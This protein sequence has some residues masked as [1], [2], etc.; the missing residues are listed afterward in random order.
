MHELH[1]A[2]RKDEKCH[3]FKTLLA[4]LLFL[5]CGK[6]QH[7]GGQRQNSAWIRARS[8]PSSYTYPLHHSSRKSLSYSQACKILCP[9][10][11]TQ[12]IRCPV[13]LNSSLC[14]AAK[15]KCL[16]SHPSPGSCASSTCTHL[17]FF[18]FFIFLFSLPNCN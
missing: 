3:S 7:W 9:N 16:C 2:R 1:Q 17:L 5:L 4:A 15:Q 12:Q 13:K 14:T 18:F 11:P 6:A 10:S 8:Q